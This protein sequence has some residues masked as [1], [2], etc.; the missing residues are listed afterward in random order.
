MRKRTQGI[1]VR[2]TAAEKCKIE[3]SAAGCGLTVARSY[4][5][6]QRRTVL[7]RTAMNRQYETER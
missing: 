2:V 1:N 5:K 7:Q 6:E 4:M 3:R